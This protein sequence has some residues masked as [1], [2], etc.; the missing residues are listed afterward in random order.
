MLENSRWAPVEIAGAPVIDDS[1]ATLEFTDDERV[2]GH[3]GCNRY[4]G[5]VKFEDISLQFGAL[6]TTEMA[7]AAAAEMDQE[8]RLFA[9]FEVTRSFRMEGPEL[10]LLDIEGRVAVRLRPI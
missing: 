10:V 2:A 9:A 8:T 5:S 6:A 4:S 3:G 7:C 1:R